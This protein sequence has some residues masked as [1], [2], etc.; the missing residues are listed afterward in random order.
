MDIK[1]AGIIFLIG[2]IFLQI[3]G[4]A[5]AQDGILTGTIM[6]IIGLISGAVFGFKYNLF[7]GGN[8]AD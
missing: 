1:I 2:L 8:N 3:I 6:G 4:W 5:Y 7:K